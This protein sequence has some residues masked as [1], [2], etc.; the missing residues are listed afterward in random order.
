MQRVI[1]SV[2]NDLYTD[3]RVHKVCSYL[4]ERGFE[5]LLVGRLRKNS[6]PLKRSYRTKRMRLLFDKGALFYAEFNIRLFLFLLI[7]KSSI[8]VANDL[9]TLLANYCSLPFKRGNALIYDTHEYFTEV[10]ELT[11]RPRVRAVWLAI[12]KWIFPKLENVI[13]VNQSIADAY[14]KRYGKKVHIVRNISPKWK[15]KEIKSR[16]ELGLPTTGRLIIFQGAGI[17]VDRGAE[18]A[19][20][21]MKYIEN[22]HLIFVGDG[23]VISDLKRIVEEEK[24]ASK[25]HIFGK[26]PYDELLNFT[27]HADLGLSLDKPSN[28]NYRFSLPNKLF[29]Y[30][31]TLTPVLVS[32]VIEVK[33]IVE[34]YQLGI[35]TKTHDPKE[36]AQTINELFGDELRY[37][38]YIEQC[39]KAGEIESWEGETKILDS[40]YLKLKKQN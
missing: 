14:H 30:I 11:A 4:E 1:V 9:D 20:Y 36:L 23:D 35:V 12:E 28:D 29:D 7:H 37:Q 32:D 27:H 34:K 25:V 26:R 3:Q 13:T 8:L 40:I 31:H 22:A 5:V 16:S 2:S 19:V 24:L 38:S 33:R 6:Q 17:N 39:K 21:A 15:A 10:P 18:E